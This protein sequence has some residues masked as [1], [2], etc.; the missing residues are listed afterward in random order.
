MPYPVIHQNR[1]ILPDNP[2]SIGSA[3]VMMGQN[4]DNALTSQGSFD[5]YTGETGMWNIRPSR[6][7]PDHTVSVVIDGVVFPS[8]HL[9]QRIRTGNRTADTE[10]ISL[11]CFH[12]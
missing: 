2:L 3:H 4:R 7:C 5:I 8:L 9:A 11:F 12:E 1:L 10:D 6:A